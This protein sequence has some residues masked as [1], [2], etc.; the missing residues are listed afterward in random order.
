MN[1]TRSLPPPRPPA[2]TISTGFRFSP[3]DLAEIDAR[4]A[5]L[6]LSRTDYLTGAALNRLAPDGE[7]LAQ[8]LETLAGRVKR[9]EDMAFG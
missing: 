2:K 5:D 6:N 4:A 9:L 3:A 7:T 1:Q 8:R